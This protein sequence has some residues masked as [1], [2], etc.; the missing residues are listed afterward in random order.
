MYA[1]D[2]RG[3]VEGAPD[4]H[5]LF[6]GLEKSRR[7]TRTYDPNDPESAW[8]FLLRQGTPRNG[9]CKDLL[10]LMRR[11][12]HNNSPGVVTAPGWDFYIIDISDAG[13]YYHDQLRCVREIDEWLGGGGGDDGGVDYSGTRRRYLHVAAR[14]N[15]K[16]RD[17]N[18]GGG[19]NEAKLFGPL[20]TD[21][22]W[23]KH[24]H[25]NYIYGGKPRPWR[26]PVRSDAIDFIEETLNGTLY[27]NKRDDDDPPSPTSSTAAAA[28]VLGRDGR[29]PRRTYLDLVYGR[30]RT[31]DVA[32]FWC[33]KGND[34]LR[35][36]VARLLVKMQAELERQGRQPPPQKQNNNYNNNYYRRRALKSGKKDQKKK[37]LQNSNY[38]RGEL[39]SWKK[40]KKKTKHQR[41]DL[42]SNA[43]I[44][45]QN[46]NNSS[47]SNSNV[48]F[49][50]GIAGQINKVGRSYVQDEYFE[51][52]LGTKIVVISQ[53]DQWEDHW[54]FMEALA[55][56]PLVM[57]DPMS[58]LPH[59]LVDGESVVVYRSLEEL[60]RNILY[61]LEHEEERLRIAYKGHHAAIDHHRSWHDL[62]RLIFEEE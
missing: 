57:T 26:F 31:I 23:T 55:T 3:H 5:F 22:D 35:N 51:I 12:Q 1:V 33:D 45:N 32:H 9:W 34:S 38:R 48:T 15:M 46:N 29:L 25:A 17:L 13:H 44:C 19:E 37:Q 20:G 40:D 14:W 56:G 59:G 53:R 52:M 21:V 11:R 42:G 41:N 43:E 36:W 4:K 50:L 27:N 8:V 47:N 24:K 7:L 30:N 28:A 62:E 49:F 60:K 58:Y 16:G 18:A 10:D 54:R 6:D 2:L 61:Y 39:K